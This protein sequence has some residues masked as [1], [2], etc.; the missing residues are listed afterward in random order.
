MSAIKQECLTEAY[1]EK[2]VLEKFIN[3]PGLHHIAENIFV[4]LNYQSLE[5]CKSVDGSFQHYLD[6]LMANPLFFLKKFIR[7]GMSKKN[8]MDWT[9]IIQMTRGTNV[10]EIILLY[11]KLYFKNDRVVDFTLRKTILKSTLK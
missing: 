9:E 7:G 2:T 1:A 4:N 11:F 6:Q 3:I 10:R 5:A 8:E